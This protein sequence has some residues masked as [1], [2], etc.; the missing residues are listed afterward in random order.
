[1]RRL[2]LKIICK[3][4]TS[5][6]EL[7]ILCIYHI[8]VYIIRSINEPSGKFQIYWYVHIHVEGRPYMCL[9]IM[10]P[11]FFYFDTYPVEQQPRVVSGL[12]GLVVAAVTLG[13]R[14]LCLI[15]VTLN[16]SAP[17]LTSCLDP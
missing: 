1:M 6:E 5:N 8:T 13:P 7:L 10:L 9:S 16:V 17:F 2:N 15:C 3:F 4:Y 11:N 14:S 12:L